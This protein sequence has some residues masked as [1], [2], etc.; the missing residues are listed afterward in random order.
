MILKWY[1]VWTIADNIKELLKEEESN[2]SNNTVT[3]KINDVLRIRRLNSL[4][5]CWKHYLVLTLLKRITVT[6]RVL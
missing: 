4:I 3:L 2:I 5:K 6:I 1:F